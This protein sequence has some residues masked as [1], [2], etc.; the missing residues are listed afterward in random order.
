MIHSSSAPV[1]LTITDGI[2]EIRFNRPEV[3]NAVDV[4]T[5]I[6]FR[7]A[8]AAASADPATR[9][10]LLTA[11]GRAFIAGGDLAFFRAAGEKA[12]DAARELIGPIHDAVEGLATAPQPV[13]AS[14]HGAVAGAGMSV[15]LAADLA[16]AADNAVFNMAYAKVGNSPDCSAS[17]TLPRLVGLRK[18]MEIIML[19]DNLDAAEALR[20]GLVNRVV[21][22]ASLEE[23]TRKLAR[24]L[25]D[26]A[27]LALRSIK[28]L[29]RDSG[30]RSLHAQLDEEAAQF[31]GNAGSADFR[32]ALEAFFGKRK[33]KFEGR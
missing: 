13:L 16:I 10:I 20:L 11:A 31:A 12:P 21:P 28:R 29:L 1:L 18:A 6:A 22:L 17:W 3:L 26:S 4:T 14:L 9:V 27:P 19:S 2:A 30:S 8:V 33:P 32:E 23:E 7:D 5:A 24:R 25:A 15:A